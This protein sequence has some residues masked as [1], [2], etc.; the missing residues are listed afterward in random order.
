MI[1]AGRIGLTFF[2]GFITFFAPCTFPL[3]P[4]YISFIT[5]NIEETLQK[6]KSAAKRRILL[7]GLFFVAGFSFV[8]ITYGVLAGLLGQ[9]ITQYR[10]ELQKVSGV[11]V[12]FFGLFLSGVLK[13]SLLEKT[14]Q[15]D[16]PD[17]LEAGK[18]ISS[19]TV[20]SA[21]GFGWSPCIGPILGFA[22]TLAVNSNTALQGAF[23]L[24]I[25]S[26]G[27]AIP[28]LVTA[29]AGGILLSKLRKINKYLNLISIIG[30]LFLILMGIL[31]LTDNLH[32]IN[33]YGF[34]LLN[35]IG[36]EDRLYD[37]L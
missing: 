8:F 34:R 12:I 33:I 2:A 18:P 28:F 23:L 14:K 29:W 5:G 3:L 30:G 6:S 36:Y 31:L 15:I 35:F 25:F 37:L 21:F 19:F 26:L 4:S 17:F 10:D 11:L 13:I 1:D 16:P 20:G 27:L 32:I 9:T 24:L 22:L 7:N